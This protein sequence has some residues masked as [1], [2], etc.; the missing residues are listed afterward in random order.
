V[1]RWLSSSQHIAWGDVTDRTVKA[2]VVV[3]IHEFF[4]YTLGFLKR[5]RCLGPD[6]IALER[7]VVTLQLS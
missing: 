5:Q 3:V 4:D 7:L 6:A 1:N 2:M